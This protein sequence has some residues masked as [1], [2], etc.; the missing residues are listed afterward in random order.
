MTDPIRQPNRSDE[1]AASRESLTRLQAI[2]RGESVP[3][4]IHEELAREE[5]EHGPHGAA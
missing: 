3:A 2:A 1:A 5:L 4:T